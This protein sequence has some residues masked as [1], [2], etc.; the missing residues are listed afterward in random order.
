MLASLH[1]IIFNIIIRKEIVGMKHLFLDLMVIFIFGTL[2][3]GCI[4]SVSDTPVK[5]ISSEE[6]K[7]GGEEKIKRTSQTAAMEESENATLKIVAGSENAIGIDLTNSIPAR[8]V[9]FTLAG[10]KITEVRTTP[11]TAGFLA[12]FNEASGKVIVVSTA[13]DKIAPG[14][15]LIAEIICDK[16]G[17]ASLKEKIIA[18]NYPFDNHKYYMGGFEAIDSGN[19]C[20]RPVHDNKYSYYTE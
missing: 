5:T 3:V 13:G 12:K 16:G 4:K 14:T 17:S 2:I 20:P 9:Q 19:S 10:V 7:A 18:N 11:R 1:L 15:G 6:P 8:G